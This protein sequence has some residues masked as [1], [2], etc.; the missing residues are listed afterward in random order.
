MIALSN[1]LNFKVKSVYPAMTGSKDYYFV[2]LNCVFITMLCDPEKPTITIMWTNTN[3]AN[4]DGSTTWLEDPAME[5]IQIPPSQ[6][7]SE[8]EDSHRDTRSRQMYD[9]ELNDECTYVPN[10]S[11][12]QEESS[13][14]KPG[15]KFHDINFEQIP[16][17]QT[18]ITAINYEV[19]II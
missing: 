6:S 5:D 16:S 8:M 1:L 3:T 14:I 18:Y 2:K 15:R 19:A 9:Y 12:M 11:K 7:T 17:S 10:F 4:K 13:P